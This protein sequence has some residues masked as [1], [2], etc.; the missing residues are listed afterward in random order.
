MMTYIYVR[1]REGVNLFKNVPL[2]LLFVIKLRLIQTVIEVKFFKTAVTLSS[3]VTMA[4][5]QKDFPDLIFRLC[6]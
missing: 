6:H 2:I 4:T 5:F 3:A 1:G